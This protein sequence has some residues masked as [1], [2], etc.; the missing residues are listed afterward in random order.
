[1]TWC[2]AG[3]DADIAAQ[4]RLTASQCGDFDVPILSQR[5]GLGT[6]KSKTTLES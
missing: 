6:S 5:G 1:M 2:F 4:S 3:I